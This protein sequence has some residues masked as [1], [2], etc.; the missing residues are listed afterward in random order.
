MGDTSLFSD[1][2]LIN[3]LYEPTHALVP[4]GE[5]FTMN[6]KDAAY[7]VANYM[8]NVTTVIPMHLCAKGRSMDLMDFEPFVK[9]A[10]DLGAGAKKYIHPKDFFGGAALVE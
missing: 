2:K 4:I 3:D 8:P 7:A 10:T 6:Y 5:Q 9:H 1:M